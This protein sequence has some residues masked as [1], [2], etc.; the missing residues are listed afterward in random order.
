MVKIKEGYVDF[1]KNA[2]RKA[3]M[4]QFK[5]SQNKTKS[6]N[7]EEIKQFQELLVRYKKA[8]T[9][10]NSEL[11]EQLDKVQFSIKK[12]EQAKKKWKDSIK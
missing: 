10:G 12:H 11:Y 6:M 7:D 5:I 3:N 4:Y 8:E 9:E 1:T 2:F